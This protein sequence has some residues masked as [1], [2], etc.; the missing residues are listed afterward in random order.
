MR[1]E[2][3]PMHGKNAPLEMQHTQMQKEQFFLIRKSYVH[4]IPRHDL[5][6]QNKKYRTF[7]TFLFGSSQAYFIY[8]I[9]TDSSKTWIRI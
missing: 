7:I 4:H 9:D 1:N 2:Y 5:G 8:C 6:F 3:M